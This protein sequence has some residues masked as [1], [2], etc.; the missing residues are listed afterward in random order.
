MSANLVGGISIAFRALRLVGHLIKG[1]LTVTV[2]FRFLG[3]H[4]QDRIVLEWSSKCLRILGIH[5]QTEGGRPSRLAAGILFVSN[6]ISWIDV[7]GL[8]AIRTMRFVAKAE[9]RGWPVIGQLASQAG[10][11]FFSRRPQ[12]LLRLKR[13]MMSALTEGQC[14]ALFP[15]GTTSNG[16]T[17]LCFHS[18]LFESAV[19]IQALVWPVALRY[20]CADGSPAQ[21]AAFV[22]DQSL[23][24]SIYEVLRGPAVFLDICFLPILA[25]SQRDR[26]ELARLARM[27]ILSAFDGATDGTVPT[28]PCSGGSF[29]LT[30]VPSIA[31]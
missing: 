27:A 12:E 22:G 8:N 10:T 28:L 30:R 3:P 24:G 11:L 16:D 21:H 25:G 29:E 2:L 7:L 23:I 5:L 13:W 18:G 4:Q 15:E 17:V 26:Y 19:E 6:H 31:S 14:V 20:R 9:I 1:L